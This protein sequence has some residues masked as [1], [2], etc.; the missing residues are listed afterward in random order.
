MC[1]AGFTDQHVH[2]LSHLLDNFFMVIAFM[3][4]TNAATE[5]TVQIIASC[6]R[7]AS[8]YRKVI[9][10]CL[11]DCSQSIFILFLK[12]FSYGLPYA[13]AFRPFLHFFMYVLCKIKCDG[14]LRNGI[15]SLVRSTPEYFQRALLHL[16]QYFLQ[17]FQSG[18]GNV[19]VQSGDHAGGSSRNNSL[20]IT[21]NTHLT[22]LT[23]DMSVDHTRCQII[24]GCVNNLGIRSNVVFHITYC[25]NHIL[26]HCDVCRIDLTGHNVDQLS[27][28]DHLFCCNFASSGTDSFLES[29][30]CSFHGTITSFISNLFR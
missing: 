30:F 28:F 18:N 11:C 19:L 29:F 20:C 3:I 24:S 6:H 17:S 27:A 8:E 25:C 15:R 12:K 22:A 10:P 7:S 14:R 4:Q 26:V 21:G 16:C 5:I 1:H 9:L 13:V 23:V 2:S